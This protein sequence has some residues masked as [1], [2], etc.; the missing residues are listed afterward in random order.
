MLSIFSGSDIRAIYQLYQNGNIADLDTFTIS[1]VTAFGTTYSL[2]I[3]SITDFLDF[4]TNNLNN[5][6]NFESFEQDYD[7]AFDLYTNWYGETEARENALLKTLEDSGLI[8]FKG[9]SN[10]NDWQSIKLDSS[11]MNTISGDCN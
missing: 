11:S 9:N 3:D 6:D 8:L 1:V 10:F 4:A 7:D 5:D 2:K